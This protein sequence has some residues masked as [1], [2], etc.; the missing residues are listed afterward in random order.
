MKLRKVDYELPGNKA[1]SIQETVPLEYHD[2]VGIFGKN[3][4][5]KT[6]FLKAVYNTIE[7]APGI[8][9]QTYI[10]NMP[11]DAMYKVLFLNATEILQIK[12]GKGQ[13]APEDAGEGNFLDEALI[14]EIGLQ[15]YII[16]NG[17]HLL[18]YIGVKWFAIQ[19]SS[20]EDFS[21]IFYELFSSFFSGGIRTIVNHAT[22]KPQVQIDG[23]DIDAYTL[24]DGEWI[25]VF[26]L[27]L[28]AITKCLPGRYDDA[29]LLID[30]IENY[31][32]PQSIRNILKHL[33]AVFGEKGQLWIAS[34]SL[35]VLL[36]LNGRNCFWVER[37]NKE[38]FINKPCMEHYSKIR[39][40]LY[41]NDIDA[42]CGQSFRENE[43]RHYFSEFMIQCLKEP[44]TVKCI[45]QK[46]IQLRLFLQCLDKRKKE[47][48]IL[49]F[50][51]GEGRIGE[52]L[53]NLND[54]RISYYAYDIQEENVRK[55]QQRQLAKR[56][57]GAKEEIA[58]KF[59]IILLCNVLHEM[60]I[61]CWEDDLNFIF[62]R[63][64]ENGVLIFIEDLE[65]PVGEYI[66]ETG[67]LLL[68]G[69]MS[70]RLFGQENISLVLAEEE[71]YR[72]RI[73][74]AVIH[75]KGNISKEDILETLKL[76][77]KRSIEKI[78]QIRRNRK[79]DFIGQ[80]R[81]LGTEIARAAQ[82]AVNA[83][84][85][86]AYL[87]AVDA[88]AV[89]NIREFVKCFTDAVSMIKG[90]KIGCRMELE[91]CLKDFS[92]MFTQESGTDWIVQG[93][94][95]LTGT[96]LQKVNKILEKAGLTIYT[97]QFESVVELYI[98]LKIMDHIAD[99]DYSQLMRTLLYL[100][101]CRKFEG[102]HH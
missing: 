12:Y 93:N 61:W 86:A 79:D 76:L 44:K 25:E 28:I 9:E 15:K 82:L 98:E 58:R 102:K 89:K 78:W 16:E 52:A 5:G 42:Q 17:R 55:I 2:I 74:C 40:E 96:L 29:I 37:R 101:I 83:D 67:F 21:Y 46:D 94:V 53:K 97:E 66:D 1:L 47:I 39:E 41:G 45:S 59:D 14:D 81:K 7:A 6:R 87:Q 62:N 73:L 8:E 20:K 69:E 72:D 100:D 30:E 80:S 32:N 60:Y 3:G 35:D 92:D 13:R 71:R 75:S 11:E 34:H 18:T 95:A 24:S 91:K 85:A 48:D 38:T 4:A 22:W 56:V 84:I 99:N 43:V 88:D 27:L 31:L 23:L 10:E 77:K 33:E 90:Q 64:N 65:L 54:E 63:L 26:Y 70:T 68:D 19:E 49:D 36:C 51:A 50:G 57:Y